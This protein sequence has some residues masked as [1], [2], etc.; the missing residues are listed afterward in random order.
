MEVDKKIWD[1]ENKKQVWKWK[2]FYFMS[3]NSQWTVALEPYTS[4]NVLTQTFLI[5]CIEK[6]N[7]QALLWK[8]RLIMWFGVESNC[9]VDWFRFSFPNFKAIH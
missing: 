2:F 1:L 9:L 5:V 3:V 6:K 4:T 8:K 7:N